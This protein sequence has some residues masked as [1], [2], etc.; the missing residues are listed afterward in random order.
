MCFCRV[1]HV[2]VYCGE[3]DDDRRRRRRQATSEDERDF[4]NI[5]TVDFTVSTQIRTLSAV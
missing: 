3:I 4:G 5:I 2:T 1:E